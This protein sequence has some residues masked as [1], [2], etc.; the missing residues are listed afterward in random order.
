MRRMRTSNNNTK[1]IEHKCR[2]DISIDVHVMVHD[3][4]AVQLLLV[5][6]CPFSK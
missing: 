6:V 3:H 5:L 2:D 1:C 4:F